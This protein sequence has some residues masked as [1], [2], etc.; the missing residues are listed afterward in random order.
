M[1]RI[2]CLAILLASASFSAAQAQALNCATTVT[3]TFQTF[4]GQEYFNP[5]NPGYY[6][7]VVNVRNLTNGTIR[8]VFTWKD[9]GSQITGPLVIEPLR[10]RTQTLA[11]TRGRYT[12]AE[13]RNATTYT[14][15]AGAG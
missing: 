12:V 11:H 15:F 8:V 3:L 6:R 4:L 1:K 13:V 5:Q 14:C 2:A 7:H 10:D 9:T